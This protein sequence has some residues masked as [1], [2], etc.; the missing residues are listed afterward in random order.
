MPD[1]SQAKSDHYDIYSGISNNVRG[2]LIAYGVGFLVIL[3][4][5]GYLR[6]TVIRSECGTTIAILLLGGASSQLIAAL[7]YKWT[8]GKLYLADP[9]RGEPSK[10]HRGSRFHEFSSKLFDALWVEI[11]FDVVT[12]IAY[13]VATYRTFQALAGTSA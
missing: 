12:V 8:I 9:K 3:L 11:V 6:D 13:V 5:Q 7:L 2:W 10:R 1:D 4:S